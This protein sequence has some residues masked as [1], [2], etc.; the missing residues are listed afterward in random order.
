M[1][2][3]QSGALSKCRF[4][5]SRVALGWSGSHAQRLLAEYKQWEWLERDGQ[6][7]GKD[8]SKLSPREAKKDG[9]KGKPSVSLGRAGC[10]GD[11]ISAQSV[12]FSWK[13]ELRHSD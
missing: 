8:D 12:P 13:S 2:E 4:P 6:G 1:Q 3:G 10:S 9:F 5:S 11:S 7:S